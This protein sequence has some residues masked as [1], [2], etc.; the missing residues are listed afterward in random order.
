MRKLFSLCTAVLVALAVN[1]T[2]VEPGA[3]TLKAAISAADADAVIELATG[4][5]TEESAIGIGKNLTIKAAE[6]AVPVVKAIFGIQ[7]GATVTFE[8]IKFDASIAEDHLIYAN[9]AT[10]GNKLICEGCEFYDYK[11]TSSLIHISASKTLDACTINNC[12]IHNINKSFIFNENTSNA[13]DLTVSNSTI[14]N[15]TTASSY[16][17][18]VI[19][20]RATSGTIRVNQ[21]T[22]YNVQVINTDYAAVGKIKASGAT[23]SNSIF[24]MPAST[25]NLRAIRDVSA[26]NNCLTYNYT[27]DSNTGIHSDVAQNNCIFGQD[28][29]FADAANGDYTLNETSSPAKEAGLGGTHLGDPR[30]WPASWKPAE[31]IEVTAIELDKSSISVEVNDV[32]QLT[33]TVSPDNA[34]DPSVSWSSSNNS[35]ATVSGGLVTGVAVGTA[36]ITATAGEKKATCTV[37]VSAAVVPDVDFASACVLPAKKAQLEGNI[38]KMYKDE[39]Y[40]LYGDGGSNKQYGTASW[41]INV[42]KPCI[43][44]GTLNGV[45][46]GHLFVLDLYKGAELVGYIAQPAAKVWGSG[47]IA[48]DSVDHSTLMF[49]EAGEYTL[50]LRNTQEWSSGKVEGITLSYVTDVKTLYCYVD[51]AWWTG[52]EAKVNCYAKVQ[53]GP[54][55]TWPGVA[56]TE[57]EANLWKVVIPGTYNKINFVRTNPDQDTYWGAKT[58]EMDI[59]TNKNLFTITS[60]DAQ[61]DSEGHTAQGTWSVYGAKFLIAG[62]MTN[63]D[64]DPIASLEDS[65]VLHLEAGK[66]QLK[67]VDN[68]NWLGIDKMSAVAAGLYTDQDKNVCFILDAAG[69]VTVN[70]KKDEVFTLAGDFAIPEVKLIGIDGWEAATDA[71]ELEAAG[72][73]KSASKV[74]NLTGS[75]YDFKVIRADEWL[76]KENDE[77]NY[78]IKS[79]WNWVDGLKRDYEG[80]KSISLL[81]DGSGDYT[82][83]WTFATGKLE[84]TYPEK[85]GPT[86]IN[87]TEAAVKAQKMIENGQ[88]F[89]IKNG[90]T[91][92]AQGQLVK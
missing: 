58:D 80:L 91:Y 27:K 48:L 6:S 85:G 42:T 64:K 89:I 77:G 22:F 43:V 52:G 47:E 36:T 59:P 55:N 68:G 5:Y 16:Y 69:D 92:N 29:L 38:W 2:P 19:D 79:D 4:V 32:E 24:A 20:S 61:W 87:N 25:G 13:F 72:D 11:P 30:W 8:G 82:F 12:Y 35:I 90:N 56:M 84:V 37:T 65:Y 57:V 53:D 7:G 81:P 63:W 75:W 66:H 83:T 34:T 46:G 39:T 28:P 23:V 1:A 18:G 54:D 74:L 50:K 9:D 73:G 67:V 70:F 44:T 62:S 10:A 51:K 45:E 49:A 86:A 26:A 40:K 88:L 78:T 76:G 41:T 21:C 33:A 15:V 14:A 17:A 31:I 60:D 3:G 71:I